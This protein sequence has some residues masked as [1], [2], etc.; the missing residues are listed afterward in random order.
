MDKNNKNK[1]DLYIASGRRK[2]AVARIFLTEEK[3]EF[4]INDKSIEEYFNSE[5]EKIKWLKPFHIIGVSHPKSKFSATIK[6]SGSGKPS[7]ADAIVLAISKALASI[8]TEY[9]SMLR[10]QGMLTRDPRMV[11][12]KKPYMHKARKA[13][14]YSKR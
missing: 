8:N 5:T 6:V 3:G 1:K 10:K 12:R 13:P 11:E 9:N 4:T 2:T 7:Q 14:Q